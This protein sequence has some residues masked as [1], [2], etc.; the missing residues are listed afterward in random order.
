MNLLDAQDLLQAADTINKVLL[1]SGKH[2]IGKSDIVKQYAKST[3]L[4]NETMMMSL[5]D[6]GDIAGI[7][8]TAEIGGQISTVWAA[9][10]FITNIINQAWPSE[11][12]NSQLQFNDP[13][14]SAAYSESNLSA[15]SH[16]SRGALN[17]FYC[18]FYDQPND[19]LRLHYQDDVYYLAGKRSVLFLDE[20]NRAPMDV[21]NASL[22]L[23]LDKKL[24][25]H[26][27]PRVC[28]RDTL[29]VAA[30]N[31]ADEDYTTNDFDPALLDRFVTCTVEAD[32][33]AF[34]KYA[35][36]AK[37]NNTIVDFIAQSPKYLHFTPKDNSK[38][39][40]PRSWVHL[41]EYLNAIDSMPPKTLTYY[42]KGVLGDVVSSEF[43]IYYNNYSKA[44]SV[45]D[46]EKAVAKSAK[47][48]KVI[49]TM[50][51][52]VE[53]LIVDQE[54]IQL[55]EMAGKL[56][57]KYGKL[58]GEDA[59]PYLVYLYALPAESISSYLQLTKQD[60]TK[61]K[62]LVELDR[63]LNNKQLLKKAISI[64]K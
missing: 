14:L 17:D 31:P 7:P 2:G 46:I 26:V 44:L 11:L 15:T 29:V 62:N 39:S 33:K 24:N 1:I 49:E 54:P 4:H 10:Q 34:L 40:T 23:I 32:A 38:G 56:E 21:L 36:A 18:H 35:N 50:A 8:R 20:F 41:S 47:K 60:S 25:S 5:L 6:T 52:A 27:L 61:F 64:G 3:N 59:L 28:G 12:D 37:V 42:L 57:A 55:S 9:P 63:V 45:E 48:T 19:G 22:Q 58:E 16:V 13:A 30:I 43:L 53:K 51:K